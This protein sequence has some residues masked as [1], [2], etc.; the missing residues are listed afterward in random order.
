M[1]EIPLDKYQLHGDKFALFIIIV[2]LCA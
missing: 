2:I 1:L